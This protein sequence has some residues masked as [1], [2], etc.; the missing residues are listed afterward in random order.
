MTEVIFELLSNETY[1]MVLNNIFR[2]INSGTHAK[3]NRKSIT[4][5]VI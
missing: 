5:A 4:S 2:N 1:F 3:S